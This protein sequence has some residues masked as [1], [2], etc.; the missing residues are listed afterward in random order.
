MCRICV[1]AGT[2]E[3]RRLVEFLSGQPVSV[4]VCVATEYGEALMPR[5][6]NVEVSTGRLDASGMCALFEARR[7]DAVIDATHPFAVE[8]SENIAAA[9]AATGTPYHRLNRKAGDECEGA[10]LVDSIE[11]AAGYLADHPGKA[12][13]ATGSK[14]LAPYT[15]V[16]GYRD[17]FYPR[18]LPMRSSLEAC[19]AAGFSPAHILAMQ[20]PFSTEMNAAMLRAVGA[21]WL[22]TKASGSS[23]GFAEKLEAARQAGARCIVIGRPAQR[24]GLDYAGMVRWL[25]GRYGLRAAPEVA[26]VGIGMGARDTLTFEADRVLREA[27]CVIGARRMLEAVAG[28]G[29]PEF[30]EITPK[31]IVARIGEHPEF[32]RIAVVMSGDTGFYSGAKRLLPL[33]SGISVRVIPGLST[34]QVLCARAQTGWEDVRTVSLHGREGSVVPELMKWGRVFVLTDGTD[35]VQRI[36]RDLCAAG[37]GAA[38]VTVGERLSYEDEKVTRGT[39]AELIGHVCAPLSAMLLEYPTEVG[40]LSVGLPDEAFLRDPGAEGSRPVPMTKSEVR[41]VDLSKLRL[42]EDALVYDIGAGTGSV[43]VELAL[44]CPR[45]RV[46]AIECREDAAKLIERNAQRFGLCNLEVV[47]GTAPEALEALPSPSHAFIG[48][49]SGNLDAIV[50]ALLAKNPEVRIV[51]NAIALETVGEIAE[52]AR[53]RGFADCEIVQLSLARGKRAGR[54]HLMT[55]L[56]PVTIASMQRRKGGA[57]DED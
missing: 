17:R 10:V 54:Y 40:A 22:V 2:T 24:E 15:R 52:I 26:V 45:G 18:V 23:G 47:R 35:A 5:S 46:Y 38:M 6:G 30:A 37:M 31:R 28:Y 50:G 36:C 8:V 33:L 1:F 19:E 49:S 42:T 16:E 51:I 9:C 41:A 4:C 13:L 43:S 48:G 3:G 39:A 7:F 32:R 57:P 12:L 44:N 53:A 14:E 11:A 20:G 56:N 29:K 34:L 25:C 55:G 21:E 27:D